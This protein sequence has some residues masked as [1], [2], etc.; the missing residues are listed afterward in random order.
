MSSDIPKSV[1]LTLLGLAVLC[2]LLPICSAA[3]DSAG[4]PAF[5]ECAACH[6]TDGANGVG[7]SLQ[8]VVGRTSGTLPGFAF[9]N[10]MKRAKL[11]WTTEQLDKYIANPQS[12]VPGNVMPYAGMT[13]ASQRAALVTY[14]ATLK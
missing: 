8:G 2:I 4:E 1:W 14:L 7:P 6:S 9:S 11:Q 3:A 10:A 5:V 13:D 12:V